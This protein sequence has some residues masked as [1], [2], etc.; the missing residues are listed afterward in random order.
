[1]LVVRPVDFP[2]LQAIEHLAHVA[3]A[4]MATLPV[5][6]NRLYHLIDSTQ[7][8]LSKNIPSPS[9]ESYHF[10]LIES[11]SDKILGIA[12]IISAVG[13]TAPFYSYRLE[14]IFHGSDT[15]KIYS[16]IP[17]L[18]LCHDYTGYT[19]LCTFYI[20]PEAESEEALQ[21]LSSAR[22]LFIGEQR[23]RFAERI[24]VELQGII[25]EEGRSPFWEDLGYHFLKMNIAHAN[26]LTGLSDKSFI[27][28]LMPKHPI[29]T[30]L[31]SKK[32]RA[33]IGEVRPDRSHMLDLLEQE[34]FSY[35][36]YV[37]IFDAGPSLECRTDRLRSISSSLHIIPEITNKTTG[38]PH[39]IANTSTKDFRCISASFNADVKSITPKISDTLHLNCQDTIRY[40][41]AR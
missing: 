1:M 12:G 26:D 30:P 34:G 11:E 14:E 35:E 28:D 22:L 17:A 39:I 33:A 27:A 13:M 38:K 2:D 5:E 21:L 37:D 24:V 40:I 4:T 41:S 19:C 36:G 20:L 15:L 16:R 31:L 23:Q 29:Y 3:G 18:K 32:A 6:S 10:V 25:D 9:G 7:K 8:S